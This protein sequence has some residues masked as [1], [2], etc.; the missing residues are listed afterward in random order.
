MSGCTFWIHKHIWIVKGRFRDALEFQDSVLHL[1]N[2]TSFGPVLTMFLVS[3][4]YIY[5]LII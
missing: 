3:H 2:K 4:I 1:W 5:L